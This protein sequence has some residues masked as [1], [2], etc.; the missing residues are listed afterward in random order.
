MA[1]N[2][3]KHR[4]CNRSADAERA[5]DA[6]KKEA[7]GSHWSGWM[8]LIL[9][10]GTGFAVVAVLAWPARHPRAEPL[11]VVA[12]TPKNSFSEPT[13]AAPLEPREQ[14]P[15]SPEKI[16]QPPGVLPDRIRRGN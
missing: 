9:L 10:I 3:S 16:S 5:R 4:L 14:E 2:R 13:N 11:R 6:S 7:K 15:A 1:S 12:E 8:V